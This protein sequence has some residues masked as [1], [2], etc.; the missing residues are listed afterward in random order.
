MNRQAGFMGHCPY[1]ER[2]NLILEYGGVLK[3]GVPLV[4]IQLNI[5]FGGMFHEINHPAS[6]GMA[7]FMEP[8]QST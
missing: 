2:M 8:G 1:D 4:I 3:M 7:P 5:F 6:L